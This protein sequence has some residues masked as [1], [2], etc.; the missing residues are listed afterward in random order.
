LSRGSLV[1]AYIAAL[2]LTAVSV[3]SSG[4]RCRIHTGEPAPGEKVKARYYFRPSHAD[5]MFSRS[6]RK[7]SQA[8]SRP[9]SLR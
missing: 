3:V 2:N 9:R 5:L 1:E 6:A 8:S 4:R 7:A